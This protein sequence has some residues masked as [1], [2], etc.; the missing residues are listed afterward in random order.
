MIE[1]AELPKLLTADDVGK[2]L[3]RHPRTVTNLARDGQ[4]RA[5][6]LGHRSVRFDPVDV[7]AYIDAHRA[8][9]L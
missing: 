4:L 1:P 7:Q 6:R 2:I 9:A 3:G 8:A 5:I